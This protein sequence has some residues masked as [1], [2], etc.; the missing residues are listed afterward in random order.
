[1]FHRK[2]GLWD[3][4]FERR[5]VE[6]TKTRYYFRFAQRSCDSLTTL[7]TPYPSGISR[8]FRLN[9]LS[10][11]LLFHL[12]FCR[13]YFLQISVS[14]NTLLKECQQIFHSM[15]DFVSKEKRDILS[16]YYSL[17]EGFWLFGRSDT[18]CNQLETQRKQMKASVGH[19]IGFPLECL[20]TDRD[21]EHISNWVQSMTYIRESFFNGAEQS[22]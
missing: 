14:T 20:R 21:C 18:K 2:S 7:Q 4:D 6:F 16:V 15:R 22:I 9:L 10:F 11:D 17:S 5:L 1:M 3:Q 12:I 8:A 19:S 13:K